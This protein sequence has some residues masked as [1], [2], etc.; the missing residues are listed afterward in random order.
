[1]SSCSDA[2]PA[3]Q[4]SGSRMTRR[5]ATRFAW[6]SPGGREDNVRRLP[7]SLIWLPLVGLAST[8]HSGNTQGPDSSQFPDVHLRMDDGLRISSMMWF[9]NLTIGTWP[10]KS[11]THT[12]LS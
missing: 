2:D 10:A 8:R 4:L 6:A 12:S 7:G 1:M 11:P 9:S 5:S 3:Q